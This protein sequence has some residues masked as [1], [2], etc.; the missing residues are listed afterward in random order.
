MLPDAHEYVVNAIL[1]IGV[2]SERI[3]RNS[4]ERLTVSGVDGL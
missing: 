3:A 2:V 1:C 4:V